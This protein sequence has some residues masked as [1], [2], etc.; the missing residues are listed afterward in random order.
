MKK[1]ASVLAITLLAACG[2]S[3]RTRLSL[4]SRS[5]AASPAAFTAAPD[6]TVDRV[7]IVVDRVNLK[8]GDGLT[9]V[10]EV[11]RAP[12]LID[13]A[14]A[15]FDPATGPEPLVAFDAP[16]GTF[17]EIS[18]RIHKINPNEAPAGDPRF[19]DLAGTSPGNGASV[20]VDGTRLVDGQ[21]QPF[22]FLAFFEE[23]L[24]FRGPF[25]VAE[26]VPN[27]VTLAVDARTW[28]LGEGGVTL[29]PE[30]DRAEI[31]RNIKASL[32]AFDDDDRDGDD[33]LAGL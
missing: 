19:T 5:A 16:A 2:S 22:A 9:E 10:Q 25:V 24:S 4:S 3:D 1:L 31:E 21:P 11:W 18:F 7:R 20:R 15:D 30:V 28:F 8:R 26:G 17:D 13:L 33:D 27:N 29:D 14:D 12:F 32:R 23:E 6:L